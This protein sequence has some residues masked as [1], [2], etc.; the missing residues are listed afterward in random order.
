MD[1]GFSEEQIMLGDMVNKVCEQTLP[2][3]RLR[4]LEGTE[5]GYCEAFWS[6]LGELGITGLNI[7]SDD[8][9]LGLGLLETVVVYE[10]FGR[11]LAVSPHHCSSML[12]GGLL[13]IQG[14]A[15]QK[16]QWLTGIASGERLLTVALSEPGRGTQKNSISLQAK[17]VDGGYTITGCKHLVPYARQADAVLVLARGDQDKRLTFLVSSEQLQENATLSYQHN[18]AKDALY[19]CDFDQ[20]FVAEQHRLGAGEQDAC[21]WSQWQYVNDVALLPL[22]A[23]AVGAA[24][25][26]HEISNEYANYRKA[27]GRPIG[28]F[29]SIAHYLADIVVAI[30]GARTLVHQA[31]WMKDRGRPFSKLAMMAKLQACETFRRAAALAIQIHGGIGYTL[32]ADPQLFFR[33]AKQLQ[34]LNGEPAELER[35]IAEQLF[36]GAQS[37]AMQHRVS[38][39]KAALA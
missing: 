14:S 13:A 15:A 6:S 25:R 24:E 2:L 8:G 26:I 32:E 4:E 9:G 23:Y 38:R 35:R 18:H 33:R 37:L 30:D 31:A 20:L 19:R 17:R 36:P 34:L 29:Q 28:G 39:L 7:D 11:A 21:C 27:F 5:P 16:Q 12:A 10:Q 1:L 3:T 22:A